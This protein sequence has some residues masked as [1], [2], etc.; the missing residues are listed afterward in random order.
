MPLLSDTSGH[1]TTGRE[2]DQSEFEA[3]VDRPVEYFRDKMV[4]DAGCGGGR[5]ARFLAPYTRLYVGVDYSVACERAREFCINVP[6]AH[7][8]QADINS[9]P[10]TAQ[11]AFDF[12]FSH[13]VLH[14]TPDTRAA[15][16]HCRLW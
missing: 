2:E 15:F 14:H 8:I 11:T 16:S 10:F 5:L 12:V 3:I 13:G 9:L 6:H 1:T 7:F 4:L